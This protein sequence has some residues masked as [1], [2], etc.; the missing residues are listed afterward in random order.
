MSTP[1]SDLTE[2]YCT[3]EEYRTMLA[4]QDPSI[5]SSYVSFFD[6]WVPRGSKVLDVG[7]GVGTSTRLLRASG[8]AALGVDTSQ[9]FLPSEEGFL[10]AD[11]SERTSLPD[12]GFGA[13]GALNVLEHV[14][15]PRAFLNELVRVVE[16]GGFV[17]LSSPNL[18]SPLVALRILIDLA[19]H[20]TPYLGVQRPEAAIG[21]LGRNLARSTAAALGRD[22][23]AP[24]SHTLATGI[25]G[26]DADAVYW[27]NA[28]EVR[29]Q[30]VRLG[31]E[32]V[33]YQG[34][35]R[36][37]AARVLAHVL[38]S[39]AG[40]LTVVV[41]RPMGDYAFASR[42]TPSRRSPTLPQA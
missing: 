27:T 39:F 23:F 36:S 4:E 30:L 22:A 16:P 24:R 20:R 41:R 9:Q 6:R 26:Y 7:C 3:S 15:R 28:A 11:F 14:P 19:R 18:T 25:V 13:A 10:V 17:V 31:C 29:R 37:A 42:Y 2:Y 1:G 32:V 5:F 8:F 35:G 12:G 21:V 33:Q 34:E 38:P 40:Q